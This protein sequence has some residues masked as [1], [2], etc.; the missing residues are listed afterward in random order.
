MYLFNTKS[1]KRFPLKEP[2]H[3]DMLKDIKLQ[4]F[5]EF[6]ARMEVRNRDRE[7]RGSIADKEIQQSVSQ[8]IAEWQDELKD[9]AEVERAA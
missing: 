3:L 7:L 4:T 8:R 5:E 2:H 6:S 1:M 9:A